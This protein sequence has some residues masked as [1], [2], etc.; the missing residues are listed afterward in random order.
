MK[1]AVQNG[2]RPGPATEQRPEWTGLAA[3]D[4]GGAKPFEVT[5]AYLIANGY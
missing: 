5:A 2:L 3:R 1:L 4:G